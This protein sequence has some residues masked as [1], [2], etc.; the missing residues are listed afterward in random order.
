MYDSHCVYLVEEQERQATWHYE[1][2]VARRLYL[3]GIQHFVL[4]PLS[5]VVMEQNGKG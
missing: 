4:S 2:L 5:V 3:R 1:V